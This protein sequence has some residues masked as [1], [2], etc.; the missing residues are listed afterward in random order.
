MQISRNTV[1]ITG[2]GSGIGLALA[3]AFARAEN[4]LIICGRNE[5]K[6]SAAKREIPELE[7]ARCD[8]AAPGSREQL[9]GWALERFPGLNVLVNNA[10]VTGT[11]DLTR[12][13]F[14]GEAVEQELLTDLHAPI[15]MALRLIPH[16][17]RQ[18]EAAIINVTSGLAYTPAAFIPVYSAAKAAVH[19]W[20]RSLRYQLRNTAVKVFEVLPPFV[21]TNMLQD[22]GIEPPDAIGPEQVA[23]QVIEQLARGTA[24]IRIGRTKALYIAS[25]IAPE[26]MFRTINRGVEKMQNETSHKGAERVTEAR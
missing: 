13:N 15:D 26:Y 20:T 12:D 6:L 18:P 23:K 16:L 21:R 19:A 22:L 4:R 5:Q 17:R 10:G 24:E 25:R 9:V 2:G 3:K 7:T 11:L 14:D 1:L 8:L